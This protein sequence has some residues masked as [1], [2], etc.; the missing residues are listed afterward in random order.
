[1][2]GAPFS[3]ASED[4]HLAYQ[5]TIVAVRVDQGE[6]L[7]DRVRRGFLERTSASGWEHPLTVAGVTVWARELVA[8]EGRRPYGSGGR[9][10][11][12]TA[13]QPQYNG[14]APRSGTMSEPDVT[15]I[16]DGAIQGT[17]IAEGFIETANVPDDITTN[18]SMLRRLIVL[19]LRDK[20]RVSEEAAERYLGAHERHVLGG[21]GV[22]PV[23]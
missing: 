1:M 5:V 3:D 15:H 20:L 19:A 13:V 21:S 18:P 16:A 23:I 4:A 2:D 22:S 14:L 6:W 10:N 9:R 7:A 17:Y 12:R 11:V 8:D